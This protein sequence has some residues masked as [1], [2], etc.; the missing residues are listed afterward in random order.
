MAA[1]NGDKGVTLGRKGMRAGSIES[2]TNQWSPE[3][4]SFFYLP[5]SRLSSR[6]LRSTLFLGE[7]KY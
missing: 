3:V 6:D 1:V 4:P 7:W 5:L 2:R